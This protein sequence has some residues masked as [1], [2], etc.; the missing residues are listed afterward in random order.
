MIKEK[1]KKILIIQFRP[2]GDVLLATAGTELLKQHFPDVQIHFLV[3][4][5]FHNILEEHPFIDKVITIPH[6]KGIRR[7][8]RFGGWAKV[9]KEKYDLVMDYQSG[10]ESKLFFLFLKTKYRL[11]WGN[12]KYA[13]LLNMKESYPNGVYAANRNLAMLRPLGIEATSCRMYVTPSQT[14]R[15]QCIDFFR[16]KNITG[17][18]VIGIAAG[19]KDPRKQWFLEGFISLVKK[20]KTLPNVH[21]IL[22]YAPNELADAMSV[23]KQTKSEQ[24]SLYVPTP[25][26]REVAALLQKLD[27]LVCNEGALNHLSCATQTKTLCLIGPTDPATWSPQGYFPGHYHLQNPQ[28]KFRKD[29]GYD[30]ETVFKKVCKLLE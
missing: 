1:I 28:E 21:I 25:S 17:K 12:K 18:K 24:V 20:I 16:E 22:L 8:F 30:A 29:F 19:S 13:F 7:F 10:T 5:P 15:E 9:R 14:G 6:V 11:G 2:F 27:V 3:T 26:M 4:P 23:Y